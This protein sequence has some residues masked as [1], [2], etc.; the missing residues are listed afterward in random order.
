LHTD[1]FR[2][3]T[4]EMQNSFMNFQTCNPNV[5]FQARSVK[6]NVTGV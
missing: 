6:K 1:T 4:I 2:T 3:D 5:S